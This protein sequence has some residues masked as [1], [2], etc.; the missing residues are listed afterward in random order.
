LLVGDNFFVQSLDKYIMYI[1]SDLFV[2]IQL[3]FKLISHSRAEKL[4][5]PLSKSSFT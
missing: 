4:Q 5:K 1:I 3:A 2:M